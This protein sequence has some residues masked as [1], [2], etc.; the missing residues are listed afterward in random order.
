MVY[1]IGLSARE[2]CPYRLGQLGRS[3]Q[4]A[5]Q[6]FKHHAEQLILR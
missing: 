6:Q 2:V 3:V 5:H 1:K 4:A